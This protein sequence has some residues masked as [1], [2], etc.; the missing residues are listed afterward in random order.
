MLFTISLSNIINAIA[1][2]VFIIG[3]MALS[4]HYENKNE[5]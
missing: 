5:K 3:A 1:M 4:I 2:A